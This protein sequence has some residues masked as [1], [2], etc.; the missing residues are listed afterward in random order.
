MPERSA[1]VIHKL[2][3]NAAYAEWV[4]WTGE[5]LRPFGLHMVTTHDPVN[6]LVRFKVVNTQDWRNP[7]N[8]L[9]KHGVLIEMEIPLS[10]EVLHDDT[11]RAKA[12]V[13]AG[14]DRANIL[15]QGHASAM[16]MCHIAMAV[17]VLRH[18]EIQEEFLSEL[19]DRYTD[20]VIGYCSHTGE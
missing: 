19:K 11:L 9:F 3:A 2:E 12:T 17:S 16:A 1:E 18:G 7:D 8:H 4:T 14:M 15:Q 5:R 6:D 13:C 20:T 10:E